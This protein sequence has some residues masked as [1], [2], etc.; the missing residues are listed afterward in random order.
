MEWKIME[1]VLE[2]FLTKNVYYD[3]DNNYVILHKNQTFLQGIKIEVLFQAYDKGYD[4]STI[5]LSNLIFSK[6]PLYINKKNHF[7]L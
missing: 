4:I 7:V 1:K 6:K 5:I 3:I 2:D